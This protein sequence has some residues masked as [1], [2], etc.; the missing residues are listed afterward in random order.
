MSIRR[1]AIALLCAALPLAAHAQGGGHSVGSLPPFDASDPG[2]PPV[3][4][5]TLL[6]SERYW[7]Y[8]TEL[9]AAWPSGGTSIP[10]GTS[11]VLIRVEPARVARIDFGRD[12]LHEIPIDRTDL[13]ARANR[14]REGTLEK[15]AAN[16]ALAIGPRLLDARAEPLAPLGFDEVAA[17]R[18]FLCVFGDPST[19][20]LRALAKQLAPLRERDGLLTILFPDGARSDAAVAAT[21]R[22]LAW[23]VPFLFQHLAEPYARTLLD[24]DVPRPA[25]LLQTSEGRLLAG[26]GA[27]REVL[28]QIESALGRH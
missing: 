17:A 19:K 5:E 26:P 25:L 23:P 9:V 22:E 8:Q 12:G 2:A 18:R 27:P 24:A 3:T 11:G 28:P 13:V 6:A 15:L 20:E 7:P 16:F 10:P 4:E 21:L 14:V 1:L